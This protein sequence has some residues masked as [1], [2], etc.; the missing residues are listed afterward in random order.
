MPKRLMM[1]AALLL[2]TTL[3]AASQSLEHREHSA[4]QHLGGHYRHMHRD[5]SGEKGR[6]VHSVC[7]DWDEGEGWVWICR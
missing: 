1:M 4:M 2:A 6:H 7:W 3:P 5:W